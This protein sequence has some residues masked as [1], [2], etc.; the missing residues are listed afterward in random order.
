MPLTTRCTSVS[1]QIV[2]VAVLSRIERNSTLGLAL[3]TSSSSASGL[4]N[5]SCSVNPTTTKA[6]AGSLPTLNV[7]LS[8]LACLLIPGMRFPHLLHEYNPLNYNKKS[9]YR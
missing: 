3:A 8:P 4:E 6:S 2:S 7:N 9:M 5:C 1:R